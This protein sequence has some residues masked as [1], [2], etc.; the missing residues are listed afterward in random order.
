MGKPF[1]NEII[2]I[3]ISISLIIKTKNPIINSIND[4]K[5]SREYFERI[6]V[7]KCW[8]VMSDFKLELS[9]LYTSYTLGCEG[10]WD[11]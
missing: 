9:D 1:V 8:R 10:D 3:I 6:L 7:Y 5:N 4:Q 11:T 2:M